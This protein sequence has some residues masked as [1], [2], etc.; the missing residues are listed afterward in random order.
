MC[1][2]PGTFFGFKKVPRV[3]E[4]RGGG[5]QGHFDNAQEL[6]D[7]STG[8]LPLPPLDDSVRWDTQT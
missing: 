3:Q 2:F 8:W 4:N 5:C 1:I 6:A 7:F